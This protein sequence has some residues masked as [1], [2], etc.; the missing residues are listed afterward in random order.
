LHAAELGE[1]IES[2]RVLETELRSPR[3]EV[4]LHAAR[5]LELLGDRAQPAW[6]AMREALERARRDEKTAGDPAMFLRFSLE[7]ALAQ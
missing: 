4:A 7:S 5:A 1:T 3:F 6:P 2:L